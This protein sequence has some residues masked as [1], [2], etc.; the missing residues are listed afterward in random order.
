MP[1]NDLLTLYLPLLYCDACYQVLRKKEP[2]NLP[3]LVPY[4][5][6]LVAHTVQFGTAPVELLLDGYKK[7]R[8][9]V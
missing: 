9:E 6:P 7:V 4:S 2:A 5:I 3:P 1:E 8:F